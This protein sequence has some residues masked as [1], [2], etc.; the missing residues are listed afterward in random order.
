M[1]CSERPLHQWPAVTNISLQSESEGREVGA[2]G[3]Y[4]VSPSHG[5]YVAIG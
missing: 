5:A 1:H 4:G 2:Y 3:D